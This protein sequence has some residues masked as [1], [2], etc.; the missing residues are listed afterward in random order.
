MFYILLFA[1]S[2]LAPFSY[3]EDACLMPGLRKMYT[4]NYLGIRKN[5]L[6]PAGL[7]KSKL[8][9]NERYQDLVKENNPS[10]QQW[11]EMKAIEKGYKNHHARLIG[12]KEIGLLDRNQKLELQAFDAT[13]GDKLAAKLAVKGPNRTPRETARYSAMMESGGN[14]RAAFLAEEDLLGKLSAGEKAELAALKITFGDHIYADIKKKQADIIKNPK[15]AKLTPCERDYM[16][17]IDGILGLKP[18][19]DGP[20]T[21]T[22]ITN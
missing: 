5:Y 4:E 6:P 21:D 16:T 19:G 10:Q 12:L 14:Y 11:A 15:G 1:L 18:Q 7:V 13:N 17:L 22:T 2:A 3:S 8:P 20:A 9:S